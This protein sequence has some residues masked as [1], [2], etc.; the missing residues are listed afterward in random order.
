[1]GSGIGFNQKQHLVFIKDYL[2]VKHQKM[3]QISI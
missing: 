1:M 3:I 2:W